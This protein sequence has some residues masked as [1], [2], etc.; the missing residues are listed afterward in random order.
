MFDK[1][2]II[3]HNRRRYPR[4][5]KKTDIPHLF[6]LAVILFVLLYLTNTFPFHRR[7]VYKRIIIP[8]GQ[9]LR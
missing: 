4:R 2:T 1:T 7:P 9:T 5:P 6:L 8:Y 3:N